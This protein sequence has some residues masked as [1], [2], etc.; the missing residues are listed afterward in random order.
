MTAMSKQTVTLIGSFRRDGEGLKIIFDQLTTNFDLICPKSI[1][2]V[3]KTAAFV[4]ASHE[5]NVSTSVIEERVLDSIQK[6]DFVWLFAPDGYVGISAAFEIGV[7]HSLGIPI[8]SD[9]SL[10][11]EMLDTMLTELVGSPLGVPIKVHKPGKGI[12]GLQKYY[13][14]VSNRR[15]W[16]NESPR[17]TML[18]L[19]EEIGEL[20]RAIRKSEGLKRDAG[21][22][23]VGLLDELADVQLY[24]VHLANGLGVSLDEAVN[25]KE[26]KNDECFKKSSGS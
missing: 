6:S 2:F 3:D 24:L 18:L 23:D 26:A 10:Y 7:A 17:D 20:A 1:E 12:S 8:Y 16:S 14:K 11:D 9:K 15:G 22:N 4:K 19:T 5:V 25:Q 13:E 21:Y